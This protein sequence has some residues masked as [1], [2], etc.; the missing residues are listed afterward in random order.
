MDMKQLLEDHPKTAIVI[1]QWF[2]DIMLEGI[3]DD[4]IPENFKEYVRSQ[5]IDNDKVAGM[6]NNSPRGLF[7]VFDS[8]KIYVETI[9]DT[10]GIFWWK[11]GENQSSVGYEKRIDADKASIVEAF[12]LLEA[13]L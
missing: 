7:D 2:L 13:K 1:K 10:G 9:V 8:H 12:K 4:K 11:I 3:K 6:L 5:G